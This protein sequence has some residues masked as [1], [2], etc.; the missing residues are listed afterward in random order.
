MIAPLLDQ[1][2]HA[3]RNGRVQRLL[4]IDAGVSMDRVG[5]VTLSAGPVGRLLVPR[6]VWVRTF[7]SAVLVGKVRPPCILSPT[8][9]LRN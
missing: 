7:K 6:N 9:F 4:M 8:L 3:P 2:E 5:N 1:L